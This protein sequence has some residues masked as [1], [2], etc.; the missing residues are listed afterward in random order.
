[1][2][3]TNS[4]III[5]DYPQDDLKGFLTTKSLPK[6]NAPIHRG[7]SAKK[8]DILSEPR[9]GF[10]VTGER[11]QRYVKNEISLSAGMNPV[12]IIEKTPPVFS[13]RFADNHLII[14]FTNLR[15][16]SSPKKVS[17][18]LFVKTLCVLRGKTH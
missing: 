11:L 8:A 13:G 1:M 6:N 2:V 3:K 10:P 7:A 12:V 15:Y 9:S 17:L 16:V 14:S 5:Y 18:C 4:F